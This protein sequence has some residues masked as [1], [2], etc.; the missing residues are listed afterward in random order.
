MLTAEEY[1]QHMKMVLRAYDSQRPRSRQTKEFRLGVSD[2]GGC[3]QYAVYITK[4]EPFSDAP[5]TTAAMWGTFLH[6]GIEHARKH[7]DPDIIVDAEVLITLS[8]GVQLTGHPDAID[9]AEN[10]LT[11]DKTVDGLGVVQ[12][13]G[14]TEHQEFQLALYALGAVQSGLLKP[15]DLTVR[16]IWYDRSGAEHEPHVWQK[17]WHPDDVE[18]A[19]DWLD[20]VIYAVQHEEEA[21]KTPAFDF[22]AATCP[23][24]SKCRLPDLPEVEDI[25]ED[26]EVVRAVESYLAGH[27]LEGEGK[28][29]KKAGRALIDGVSGMV[30]LDDGRKVRAR[31]IS[32]GASK[33]AAT[34][35]KPYKR[36]DLRE[37]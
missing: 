22:C 15:D 6:Q 26:E 28:R 17:T 4:Q 12:R 1:A 7:D 13:H 37:V 32:I 34:E 3:P 36:L 30:E 5:D 18:P 20:N 19:V 10:S 35:R 25:I 2:I 21:E 29:L 16:L 27:E 11:D 9:Q 24:F 8:N 31:W 14:P 33:I 23:Y